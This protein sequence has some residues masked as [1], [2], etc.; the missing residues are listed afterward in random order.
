MLFCVEVRLELEMVIR[1]EL[2]LVLL[3]IVLKVLL[4]G[5]AK[6]LGWSEL[7]LTEVLQLIMYCHR[8]R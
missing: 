6:V 3:T 7:V 4:M 1:F 2:R 5:Y 8:N